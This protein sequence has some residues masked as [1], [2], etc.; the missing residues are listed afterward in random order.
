MKTTT[1]A[2]LKRLIAGCVA[3]SLSAFAQAAAA[4]EPT[5]IV[6]METR[7]VQ[8][9]I[10]QG[11]EGKV[12]MSLTLNAGDQTRHVAPR[13]QPVDLVVVLD[14]SGSM[15]GR[16]IQDA[17]RAVID[18][19]GMLSPA[20][21]LA[22]I[23]YANTVETVS[24]LIHMDRRNL[25][26]LTHR[27]ADIRAGGGTNLGGGLQQGVNMF[28]WGRESARQRKIILISDGLAN[29][30]ITDPYAL[31]AM[32]ANGP[33]YG[34][35]VSTVGVGYDFNETLM[36]SIA[37]YGSGNY[38]FL[39]DP[40][41]IA[42]VFEEEFATARNVV[43]SEVEIRIRLSHSIRILSS[44]G[45]PVRM[46]GDV[47]VIRPGDLL[48]GQQR[49]FFLTYQVPTG[50]ARTYHLGDI[51]LRYSHGGEGKQQLYKSRHIVS[52]IADKEAVVKS[53]DK[54]AWGEQVIQEEY[55]QLKTEVAG[56]IRKGHKEKALR[57]ITEYERKNRILNE[58]VNSAAVADNLEKDVAD[59]RQSVDDTFAGAPAEVAR[60]QKRQSK[61]LQYESYKL[62]RDK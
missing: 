30:G 17:R 49:K 60:K 8:S 16:K 51:E 18:L 38:Y 11:S 10:L 14:R 28:L 22:V 24:P 48:S 42:R 56:A 40:H 27:V 44:G 29:Q 61:S 4:G 12:S 9:K 62:R 57:S 2:S 53:V 15:G 45:Y 23:S 20:D 19:M 6:D 3:L 46:E 31:G 33:E 5:G 35:T 13:E 58:S 7:L 32:A 39:E 55:N 54:K 50:T 43:A 21:R 1:T 59:L 47:A 26:R 41:T 36:T 37:D 34:F 52:C 25:S